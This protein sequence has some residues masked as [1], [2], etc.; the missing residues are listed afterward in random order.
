MYQKA[1]VLG[2]YLRVAYGEHSGASLLL[3]ETFHASHGNCHAHGLYLLY[4]YYNDLWAFDTV[5]LQWAE[6][7]TSKPAPPPRGGCQLALHNDTLFVVG[8]HS[9]IREPGGDEVD[10]VHDDIWVIDLNTNEV[11]H[12]LQDLDGEKDDSSQ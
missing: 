4:R 10:K 1:H 6:L 11:S 3:S 5:T 9:W 12:A 2:S 7:T 8:G